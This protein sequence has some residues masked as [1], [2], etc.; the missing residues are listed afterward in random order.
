[1]SAEEI[2][3]QYL[4][5]DGNHIKLMQK[6]NALKGKDDLYDILKWWSIISTDQTIGDL[7][8]MN[9]NQKLILMQ[10]GSSSYYIN[11][12]SSRIGV[13]EFL[14]N[15]GNPWKII[16]NENGKKNKVTN[17]LDEEPIPHFYIYKEI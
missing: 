12:D 14:L 6:G 10:I 5:I 17:R 2:K 11:A 3:N 16:V 15:K 9:N 8:I 7:N 1:M 13:R 4:T